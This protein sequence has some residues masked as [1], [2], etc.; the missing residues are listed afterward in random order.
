MIVLSVNSI[1]FPERLPSLP[2]SLNEALDIGRT[3]SPNLIIALHR[4]RAALHDISVETAS[5]MPE[6]TLDASGS[7]SWD[8]NTFFEKSEVYQIGAKFKIPL[9]QRGAEYASIRKKRQIAVQKRRE[10]EDL[11]RNITKEIRSAWNTL[12]SAKVQITAFNSS[13]KANKIALD[14]VRQ[15]SAVGSRTTLDVLDAEKELFLARNNLIKAQRNLHVTAYRLVKVIGRLEAR[16]LGLNVQ[17]YDPSVHYNQ[18]IKL[19][20]GITNTS[21]TYPYLSN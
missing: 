7:H 15:E 5:L 6:V 21:D 3:E 13:V 17:L 14:G 12:E 18:V 11:Y 10:R 19:W 9:Y 4:E 1:N 2:I 16:R 8:P 20:K